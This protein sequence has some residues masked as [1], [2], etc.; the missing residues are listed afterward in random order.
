[1]ELIPRT[2]LLFVA[3]LAA[4]LL[5]TPYEAFFEGLMALAIVS[6]AVVGFL[7]APRR[8]VFYVRTSVQ[9]IAPD[10]SQAIEKDLLAVRVEL[11]R[12]WL[13]LCLRF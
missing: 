1:M 10:R 5:F 8:E 2:L 9:L 11:A 4:V 6:A 13:L 7:M 3:T 12:L